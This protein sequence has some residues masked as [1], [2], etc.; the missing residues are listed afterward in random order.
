MAAKGSK[1]S[2]I[3]EILI[4]LMALL[5]VAVIIVPNQ[6]WKEEEKIT[7]TCRNNLTS[8]YEAERFYYQ[9]NNV[10]TDSL[11][12][13]LAFVQSDSGLNK[14]QTLVSLT[15]SFTQ[16]LDNILSVPSVN[17]I[18][19]ISTAQFEITGDLVGNERYFRKYE[20]VTETSREIIRDLNRIDSSASFP[21]FSKVKLFVDT[22]RYL[23]ES[24][25]DYSLQ[26]AILRAINAVDS[27]KLYYP[28]IEREAFDQF[29]DEEYR[30]ISTF[31]SEIRATDISKVSTV[32]DRLRKF[33]DQI[34][35]K[36]QDLNTSN[37]QSDIEKLEVERK[38]LDEL[39]QKFLSP[40]F[41]M[42]T[43]R[44]SLTKLIETDSLLINLS[45][46]NFI[47]P[48]AETV[49]I[50]DT[51]QAR[52][53][54]ECPN[55]LDYFHQ[56]FQKNIEP[57]R[58]IQLYNQIRQIDAI[59]DSTRIVLDEDR[60]L[61]RRYTD[62]LLMVKELLVEMDQLSNAFFYRYAKET[63]DFIDLI[64]REKQLSILKPAIENILN[65]LDTLGTR[66]RTRDVADLEKQLNYFR[67]KLEKIDSTISE[68]R[69]PSSIRRRVVDTSEPFQAV[70]DVVTEMKNSF[71]PELGEKFH[72]VSKELEKT[73]LNALEG[74]SER[75]YVIFSKQHINHGYIDSG[76]K[77]WEEE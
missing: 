77:S 23:K 56:K 13:M 46:D 22:L 42:L 10:Y 47:C 49:Y 2:I 44:K 26:D 76:E 9:H 53:I 63:I 36:V 55:L 70:F 11:S 12:K 21:N 27:M 20:G 62:V 14:R 52:L 16:I 35:S 17:N 31:I 57:I 3:L 32:P 39:H 41:F 19:V 61:L 48:D 33:I 25:S 4:V 67:G 29:W 15:N 38:N 64:D 18:S 74:Q 7:Q 75:V 43:K 8:L 58:D 71:N 24:V 1:G 28:K 45:Q 59:F 66:T 69:L 65:P 50:I 68:M 37:I 6:I 54:V 30:K 40:E 73:L 72:E 5:L 60:Q 51:T 34:N